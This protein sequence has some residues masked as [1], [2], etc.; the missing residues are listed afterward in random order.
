[1]GRVML[2]GVAPYMRKPVNGILASE[3]AVGSS[4]FLMDLG[5]ATEYLVVNQG[6]PSG[7]SLYD[8]SCNGTWLLSKDIIG[9][10]SFDSTDNDYKNSVIHEW[11][12]GT[13]LPHRLGTI[14][15]SVIKQVKIPYV[16]GTG[17][18]AIASGENGL[19]TKVFLLSSYECGFN[20][21]TSNYIPV[22]GAKLSYFEDGTGDS[23]NNKRICNFNGS[24]VIWWNRSAGNNNKNSAW[25]VLAS[26]AIGSQDLCSTN[27]GIR[28]AII[29]PFN[30]VFDKETLLLKG[31]S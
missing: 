27:Y 19:S 4:V 16:N 18:S 28:P 17:G 21:N 12:N 14:E 15:Q 31:V 13:F 2:S 23:A 7:S 5:V 30:A 29:L 22:D 6:K 9:N 20:T 26:G 24:P 1:M 3:L 25:R 10:S 11:L 8:D